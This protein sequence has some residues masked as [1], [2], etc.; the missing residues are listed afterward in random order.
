MKYGQDVKYPKWEVVLVASD[1]VNIPC[2]MHHTHL[3]QL[4]VI[5]QITSTEP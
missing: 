3:C 5:M 2:L 1:R 4:D